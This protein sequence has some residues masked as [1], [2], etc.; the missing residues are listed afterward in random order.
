M[1]AVARDMLHLLRVI[2]L[3]NRF[4]LVSLCLLYEI[5]VHFILE[6]NAFNNTRVI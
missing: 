1:D 3:Y 6:K 5:F 4:R 2:Y